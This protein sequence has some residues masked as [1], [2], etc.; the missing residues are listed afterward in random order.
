[1]RPSSMPTQGEN[2]ANKLEEEV[3]VFTDLIKSFQKE[4]DK[5]EESLNNIEVTLGRLCGYFIE[6]QPEAVL[7]NEVLRDLN[8]TERLTEKGYK[9]ADLNRRLGNVAIQL[10]KL[11]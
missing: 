1:M 7:G 11:A 2:Y 9:M 5:F 8:I 10:N 4:N 6:R 3:P